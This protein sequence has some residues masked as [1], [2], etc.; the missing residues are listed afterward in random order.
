MKDWRYI[1]NCICN[2]VVV[3][4]AI[5]SAIMIVTG[6]TPNKL[7]YCLM[8]VVVAVQGIELIIADMRGRRKHSGA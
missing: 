5:L 2:W 3:I 8:C 7:S 1:V 4:G 6:T